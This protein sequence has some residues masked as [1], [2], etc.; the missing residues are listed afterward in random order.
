M[1]R[2][3]IW[4]VATVLLI[5]V[6][7]PNGSFPL[8]ETWD[9]RHET[10]G[11]CTHETLIRAHRTMDTVSGCMDLEVE[12]SAVVGDGVG[13]RPHRGNGHTKNQRKRNTFTFMLS[14]YSEII[15]PLRTCEV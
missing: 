4:L 7:S 3:D 14:R 11:R 10:G 5:I 12:A 8:Q 9:V 1:Q 13:S 2:P 15:M 6:L